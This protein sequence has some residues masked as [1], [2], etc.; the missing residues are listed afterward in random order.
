MGTVRTMV[1]LDDDVWL[2]I[3]KLCLARGIGLSEAVNELTRAGMQLTG[4]TR[5]VHNSTKLGL[6]VAISNVADVLERLDDGKNGLA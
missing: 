2:A 3:E 4:G 6:R 1:D 5:Y